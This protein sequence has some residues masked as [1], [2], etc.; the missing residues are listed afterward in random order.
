MLIVKVGVPLLRPSKEA[1]MLC[2]LALPPLKCKVRSK[3]QLTVFLPVTLKNVT[4][5][6]PQ[7]RITV[8]NHNISNVI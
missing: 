3:Q 6:S 1:E 8:I 2:G 7:I 5:P 4:E